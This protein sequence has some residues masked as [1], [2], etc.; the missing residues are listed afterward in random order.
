[1]AKAALV[2]YWRT[3][4][5]GSL[6]DIA[7]SVTLAAQIPAADGVTAGDYLWVWC[8]AEII[9]L[10]IPSPTSG[11]TFVAARGR[12]GT[13]ATA[14]ADETPVIV[15]YT[16]ESLLQLRTD[17]EAVS[18]PLDATL[19]AWAGTSTAADKLGYWTGVDTAAVTTFTAAA[20]TVLDDA[21]VDDMLA[22][23]GGTAPV[24]TGAIVR[25]TYVDSLISG[26]SQH[27]A[28]RMATTTALTVTYDNGSSGVGA[29][30]TN[31]GAMAAFSADG[32][33]GSVGQRVLVK[34][35]A[36]T[37]QNGIYTITTVGSGAA[38]WVLTRATDFDAAA[39][40]EVVDGAYVIIE[41]GTTLAGTLWILAANGEASYTIGTTALS[42]IELVVG[43]QTVTL[44][45]DC[46][47]SGAGTFATTV[48]KIQGI[49]VHTTAPTD[50]QFLIYDNADSRY[51]A[52]SIS[53]DA[54]LAA[55]GALTVTSFDGGTDLKSAAGYDVGSSANNVVI[56]DANAKVSLPT[57]YSTWTV[58]S[59]GAT[60]TFNMNTSN[61]HQVTLAGN[62]T[63]AVSN[64]DTGQSFLLKL[65]QDVTGS[66]TVTWFSG[67]TWRTAGGAAPTLSTTAGAAD[68]IVFECTG[69]G[70][71]DAFPDSSSAFQLSDAT[72]T[73]LAGANWAANSLAIGSG[74]DTVAQVTFAANTFPARAST[75]NLVAKTITDAALTVL[76]DTT[77]SAMVDT[78][79]GAAATGTGGLVRR[80]QPEFTTHMHS[81]IVFGGTGSGGTL[82]ITSTQH[83]TK[84]KVF[85]GAAH[86]T[87]YDEVNG[88]FG[89]GNAAPQTAIEVS[90][91]S[92]P[93]LRISN[94]SSTTSYSEIQD[95]G[96]T[97]LI[98]RKVSDS[99]QCF[100][101]FNPMC[102]DGSSAANV[103]FG[104]LTSTTGGISLTV[105]KGDA[106]ATPNANLNGNGNCYVCSNNSAFGVGTSAPTSLLHITGTRS[107]AAWGTSGAQFRSAASTITD[108]STA[109]SATVAA[110]NFNSFG[111][112]TL[113][114]TNTTITYSDSATVYI[115]G[116]PA[117]GANT[118]TLTRPW[119]I[120]VDAGACRFDGNLDF[121]QADAT[122]FVFGTG[123]GTKL[124]TATSQKLGLWNATPIVQPTTGVAAATF[125][126]NSGTAV[127]DAST[128]DGYTLGQ[129]V[130][131]LR[132]IGALA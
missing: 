130:K 108:T 17:A 102:T 43:A 106:S 75:G 40:N 100:L 74:T 98:I 47:G 78:L 101:D 5:N 20:R 116:V 3:Q 93:T 22:T 37:A 58:D 24:G 9:R 1:M 79:G 71:Y 36:A 50:A 62:P 109:S 124:G 55:S 118:P 103:R 49:T 33:T 95:T 38:N 84:G 128:F 31:A 41:E 15:A 94:A 42:F 18:Q 83:A 39:A 82:E 87:A 64:V 7:T 129:I 88:R 51:E 111:I 96:A 119:A 91:A 68:I 132:N 21:T 23:L 110:A 27:S 73:A 107:Y 8:G 61:K 126:A 29:T 63:L 28:C 127:N 26:M 6:T 2:N 77:V 13:T 35:Q 86:T 14:H 34:D 120:W 44:T 112:P 114:T 121:S 16:R 92:S 56:R 11:L 89:F 117:A 30:L 67:I 115:A 54:T 46:T 123:T 99:G 32:V 105:F 53:G 76:D 19:T 12:D 113:A 80:D 72:L 4:L 10:T 97:Q 25:K 81:P 122:N 60:V 90:A 131:A 69:A 125:V 59:Y 57:T 45:G 48:V 52:K 85:F 66:R 104:R 65:I 70:A